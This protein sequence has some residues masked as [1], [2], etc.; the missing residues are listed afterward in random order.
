MLLTH[1]YVTQLCKNCKDPCNGKKGKTKDRLLLNVIKLRGLFTP[2]LWLLYKGY[3]CVFPL[4]LLQLLH[5]HICVLISR[6]CTIS[7]FHCPL[8]HAVPSIT[9]PTV[10]TSHS[11]FVVAN[12]LNPFSVRVRSKALPRIESKTN[13]IT[14][15]YDSTVGRPISKIQR[16]LALAL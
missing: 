16:K 1:N 14:S 9:R 12:T 15:L 11:W 7:S 4:L 3:T 6:K 10:V 13:Y 5:T 8:P 2:F